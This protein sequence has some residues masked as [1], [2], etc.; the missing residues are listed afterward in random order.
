V[1]ALESDRRFSRQG[2]VDVAERLEAV[3]SR[4][5]E[6]EE[7]EEIEELEEEVGDRDPTYLRT[8]LVVRYDHK[9]FDGPASSHRFRLRFLYAFGP[10]QRFGVSFLEPLIQTDTPVATAR[11][12]GDAEA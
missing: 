8:R 3:D 5:G 11:G 4:P 7:I 1:R 6:E 2:S 12:S 10:L 9:L